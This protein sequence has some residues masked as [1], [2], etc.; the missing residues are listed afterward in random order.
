MAGG[1]LVPWPGI[2]LPSPALEGRFLTTGPGKSLEI[3]D[4][5]AW[6]VGTVVNSLSLPFQCVDPRRL[7]RRGAAEPSVPGTSTSVTRSAPSRR[8]PLLDSAPGSE[9]SARA[10]S[11][12]RDSTAT[13]RAGGRFHPW[14][15][16][17]GGLWCC[18]RPWVIANMPL[19]SNLVDINFILGP[20]LSTTEIPQSGTTGLRATYIYSIDS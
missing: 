6:E 3:P 5:K 1:I 8:A 4:F 17:A 14:P 16:L 2:G 12:R 7:T 9:S 15:C 18:L 13:S 11:R 19:I 20:L 10:T